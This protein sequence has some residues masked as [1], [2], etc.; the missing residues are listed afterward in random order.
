MTKLEDVPAIN[1]PCSSH[2]NGTQI[3]VIFI[4]QSVALFNK[5]LSIHFNMKG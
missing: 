5:K 2:L 1:K 4:K 3:I